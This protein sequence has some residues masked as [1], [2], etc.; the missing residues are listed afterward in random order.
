MV[1]VMSK[2]ISQYVIINDT[3]LHYFQGPRGE[4]GTGGINSKGKYVLIIIAIRLQQRFHSFSSITGTK[5]Q[6]GDTGTGGVDGFPGYRQY[7]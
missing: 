1:C 2:T 3:L 5:G 7:I 4:A 6:R